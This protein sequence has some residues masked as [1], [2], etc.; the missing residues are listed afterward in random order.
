LPSGSI[1][2][3]IDTIKNFRA[4]TLILLAGPIA[5]LVVAFLL[6]FFIQPYSAYWNEPANIGV[7]EPGNFL[8]QLHLVN[9]SLG[10]INLVPVLP[11]DGGRIVRG[12]LA[13][14]VNTEKAKGMLSA[15]SKWIAIA[16]LVV[17]L[18]FLNLLII[19]FAIYILATSAAD[20]QLASREFS[21]N[22]KN[23]RDPANFFLTHSHLS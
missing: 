22:Q 16:S 3:G 18:Y 9:L 2:G 5:N 1:G 17:G 11:T 19:L 20:K 7:V 12:M 21:M 6:K 4:K 10:V 8:F 23:S 14:M 13:M 15:W